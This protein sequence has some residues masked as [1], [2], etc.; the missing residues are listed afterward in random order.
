MFMASS[1]IESSN[2]NRAILTSRNKILVIADGDVFS[3]CLADALLK[4]FPEYDIVTM[5]GI[6]T[7]HQTSS[8]DTKLVLLYHVSTADLDTAVKILRATAPA[9][10]VGLVVEAVST[11][12]SAYVSQ[13]VE[14]RAIDGVLPLNLRLDVFMAAVDLLMKGGEHFPAALLSRLAERPLHGSTAQALPSENAFRVRNSHFPDL[15]TREV[16]ILNLICKGTQNK[17]IADKLRLSENTV[18]VHVRNIYKKMNV[19]NRT[20]AASRFFDSETASGSPPSKN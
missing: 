2:N 3:E 16:Q 5:T 10:S 14:T 7:L 17:I 15:T 12:E 8:W 18:K 6:D 9:P 20:E 4:K 1:G 19:R 13:L 11:L